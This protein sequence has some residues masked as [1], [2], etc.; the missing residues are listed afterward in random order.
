MYCFHGFITC[1]SMTIVW[2]TAETILHWIINTQNSKVSINCYKKKKDNVDIRK[3]L[4]HNIPS[5]SVYSLKR[6]NKTLHNVHHGQNDFSKKKNHEQDVNA[7]IATAKRQTKHTRRE[8]QPG[9]KLDLIWASTFSRH[10]TAQQCNSYLSL[11]AQLVDAASFYLHCTW[12]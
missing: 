11:S 9:N 12:L 5:F 3:R 2:S 8:V 10:T 1:I 4:K 7:F 6:T